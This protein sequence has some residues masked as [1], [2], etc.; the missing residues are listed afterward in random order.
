[1]HQY[2]N[3]HACVC[4]CMHDYL[5]SLNTCM[6]NLFTYMHDLNYVCM[7]AC[8]ISTYSHSSMWAQTGQRI[9]THVHA[10]QLVHIHKS[11]STP[12]CMHPDRPRPFEHACTN[13]P[14]CMHSC[15][16]SSAHTHTQICVEQMPPSKARSRVKQADLGLE[17][18]PAHIHVD[19]RAA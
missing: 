13:Q 2:L 8:L 4:A 9:C 16:Y 7:H 17:N 19:N 1:M 15:M 14:T 18:V 10:R 3:R 11:I 5:I 12:M 6:H